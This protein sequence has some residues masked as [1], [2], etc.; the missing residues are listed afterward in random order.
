MPFRI[1]VG[2]AQFIATSVEGIK[3]PAVGIS[4]ISIA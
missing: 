2:A 3:D 4:I 1:I